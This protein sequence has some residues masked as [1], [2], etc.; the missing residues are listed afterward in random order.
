LIHE[1]WLILGGESSFAAPRPGKPWMA[2]GI[3]PLHPDRD[4]VP[5]RI[6]SRNWREPPWSNRGERRS[7]EF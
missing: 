5:R 6:I 2:D 7:P 3:E 4:F 1:P